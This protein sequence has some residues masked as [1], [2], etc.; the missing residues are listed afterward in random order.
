MILNINIENALIYKTHYFLE[1]KTFQT[2]ITIENIQ[3]L[4]AQS[5]SKQ[6]S[7]SQILRWYNLSKTYNNQVK[8]K[9]MC[10]SLMSLIRNSYQHQLFLSLL[11]ALIIHILTHY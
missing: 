5:W 3:F 10:L 8:M 6:E 2:F 7:S 11:L 9:C 1:R 4:L